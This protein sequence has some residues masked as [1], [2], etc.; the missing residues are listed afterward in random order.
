MVQRLFDSWGISNGGT[1]SWCPKRVIR[2][3]LFDECTEKLFESK[4]I[5]RLLLDWGNNPASTIK[6][7]SLSLLGESFGESRFSSGGWRDAGRSNFGDNDPLLIRPISFVNSTTTSNRLCG[8]YRFIISRKTWLP[9]CRVSFVQNRL[10]TARFV[11][12]KSVLRSVK[13]VISTGLRLWLLFWVT[14]PREI[15]ILPCVNWC[16]R[17]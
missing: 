8:L 5:Y 10:L 11:R 12:V 2:G 3:D 13:A 16:G 14:I 9:H 7:I 4:T 6:I 15:F 1:I 17:I